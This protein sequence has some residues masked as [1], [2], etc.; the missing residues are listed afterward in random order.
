MTHQQKRNKVS[1]AY[2][3]YNATSYICEKAKT[4]M[5]EAMESW[6]NP[7]SGHWCGNKAKDLIATSRQQLAKCLGV[8]PDEVILTSGGTEGNNYAIRGTIHKALKTNDKAHIITSNIEHPSVEKVV[9]FLEEDPRV[10]VTRI[11]CNSVGI[12]SAAD[13]EKA[14]TKETSLITIMHVNNEVG[15]IQP[16]KEI[17]SIAKKHNITM[18]TDASQSVGK[19]EVNCS[20]LDIDLLTICS[21]KFYGPKGVG[22]L[23]VRN[24]KTPTSLMLG[25]GHEQSRRAGTENTV[26]IAGMAAALRY[27]TENVKK[28][29]EHTRSMRDVLIS[30]LQ[31]KFIIEVN[32]PLD[33]NSLTNTLNVAI[34]RKD[35]DSYIQSSALFEKVKET[36]AISTGSACHSGRTTVSPVHKAMGI[37]AERSMASCRISTGLSTSPEEVHFAVSEMARAIYGN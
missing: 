6:G 23:V 33:K 29:M 37:A 15:T 26:L 19:M 14:I 34:K 2:L 25:A 1:V 7:S 27:S 18:H 11:P 24:S 3:D 17:A 20:D 22:A 31:E 35:D 12:V 8:E 30:D 21:H 4:A 5:T 10:S 36:V 16:I 32:N 28:L 13:V 9:A